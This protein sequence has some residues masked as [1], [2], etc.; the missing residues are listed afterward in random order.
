MALNSESSSTFEILTFGPY[1]VGCRHGRSDDVQQDVTD[2]HTS[3][4]QRYGA[5]LP[6]PDAEHSREAPGP[7]A[8]HVLKDGCPGEPRRSAKQHF[9]NTFQHLSPGTKL[10][11]MG[12]PYG[13]GGRRGR[14]SQE[15]NCSLLD[16][17]RRCYSN[18]AS[19]TELRTPL[20]DSGERSTGLLAL[21][22]QHARNWT[23]S[24][25]PISLT[26][27]RL[28]KNNSARHKPFCWPTYLPSGEGFK[29]VSYPRECL[30]SLAD[31]SETPGQCQWTY[32]HRETKEHSQPSTD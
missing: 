13:G 20:G 12:R 5:K 28:K 18:Y 16:R 22:A 3:P 15:Q 4:S 21:S 23:K 17:K 32:V 7:N 27:P 9:G 29:G 1:E 24:S 14:T 2:V 25:N 26:K 31:G 30:R 11:L 19:Q 8:E 10:K 6:D